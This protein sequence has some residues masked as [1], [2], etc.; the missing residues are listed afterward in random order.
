MTEGNEDEAEIDGREMAIEIIL[1][2]R[3]KHFDPDIIDAMKACEEDFKDI[4]R[5][6]S[7]EAYGKPQAAE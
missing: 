1:E 7:D 3:G 6:F 2:R 5:T 4:A